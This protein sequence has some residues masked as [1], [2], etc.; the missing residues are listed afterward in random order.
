MF[1]YTSHG[2]SR[3]QVVASR[4]KSCAIAIE[5]NLLYNRSCI[6]SDS[7]F[8]SAMLQ[9]GLRDYEIRV[10]A[11]EHDC[12][13][14][15]LGQQTHNHDLCIGEGPFSQAG[16]HDLLVRGPPLHNVNDTDP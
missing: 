4:G 11:K 12:I 15:F 16:L 9:L 13:T 3:V 5:N 6:L 8:E 7:E 10:L 14:Y 2:T 1:L